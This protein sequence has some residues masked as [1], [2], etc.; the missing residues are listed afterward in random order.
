MIDINNCFTYAYSAATYADFAQALTG[1]SASTNYIDLDA[2]GLN[3]ASGRPQFLVLRVYAA[4]VTLT[5]LE[6][7]LENDEDSGFATTLIQI[8][9]WRFLLAQM[10]AGALL[11][12]QALPVWKYKRYMRMYFNVI[13]SN[14]GSGSSIVAYISDTPEPAVDAIDCV[15]S[16][17]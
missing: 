17:S 2:A 12:N 7:F 13:G 10:T 3:I 4:F 5:S 14:P 1:D 6:I 8:N 11:I 9:M 15:Q 16:G